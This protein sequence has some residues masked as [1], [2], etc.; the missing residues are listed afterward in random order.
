M[1]LTTICAFFLPSVDHSIYFHTDKSEKNETSA[2]NTKLE[3]EPEFDT[4]F[5]TQIKRA[6]GLLWSDFL[7]AYSNFEVVKWSLWWALSTCGFLQILT[8]VQVLWEDADNKE[9][10]TYNGTV[11]AICTFIGKSKIFK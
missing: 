11:E 2:N 3:I 7:Q 8:Y 1:I 6:Y 10:T 4:R 9:N 5:L